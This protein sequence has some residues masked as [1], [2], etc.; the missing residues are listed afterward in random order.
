MDA[1]DLQGSGVLVSA[2]GTRAILTAQHVLKTLPRSGR[3]PLFLQRTGEPHSIDTAGLAFLDIARGREDHVGP[4]LAALV[5]APQI[6]ASIAA[7]KLFFNLDLPRAKALEGLPD[8]RDGV[9]CAQGFLDERGVV[10]ADPADGVATKYFYN[11]SGLGG[12]DQTQ[13]LDGYDYFEF[14]VSAESR[15]G[16]PRS[17]GG[18]SG[19]GLWQVPLKQKGEDVVPLAPILSGILFYQHPTTE[20]V[21][22][23][24]AHGRRSVYEIAY[25]AITA[26]EA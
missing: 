2:G 19:G 5:L 12:P 11:F 1:V 24:R 4:D 15:D 17:W 8:L 26:S 23:V 13:E 18:M 16:A 14:P 7:K 20:T 6:G 22:G 10:A 21:S 3:I 9:W 25:A